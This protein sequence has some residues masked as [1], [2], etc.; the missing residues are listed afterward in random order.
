MEQSAL[1]LLCAGLRQ[2]FVRGLVNEVKNTAAWRKGLK[3]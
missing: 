2:S 3:P 1:Y